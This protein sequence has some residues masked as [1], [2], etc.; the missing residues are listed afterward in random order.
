MEPAV[1]LNKACLR[2]LSHPSQPSDSRLEV[3]CERVV[4]E[5]QKKLSNGRRSS[6]LVKV[7]F[8]NDIFRW[9]FH[10]KGKRL[11]KQWILCD[12]S[13]F[14]KL[15]LPAGWF[16]RET[17]LGSVVSIDFPVRVKCTVTRLKAN[18][19]FPGGFPVE[20]LHLF[21]VTKVAMAEA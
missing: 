2:E 4:Y 5:V 16:A 17:K 1:N 10:G 9:A 3:A 7:T 13:D 21:F 6:G 19:R 8:D 11:C 18:K 14:S 20:T 12:Q 15:N